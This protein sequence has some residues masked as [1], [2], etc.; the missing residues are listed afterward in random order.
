MKIR[1]FWDWLKDV[2]V[3]TNIWAKYHGLPMSSS[4]S[5]VSG[6]RLI[7]G[8]PNLLLAAMSKT[9]R[10]AGIRTPFPGQEKGSIAKQ[11]QPG[12][13]ADWLALGHYFL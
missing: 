1:S 9:H 7:S 3:S 8:L 12:G 5:S 2:S 6:I 13:T 4:M 11:C 10:R